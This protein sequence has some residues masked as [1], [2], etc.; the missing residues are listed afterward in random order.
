MSTGQHL[1]KNAINKK[2]K[3]TAFNASA[4]KYED[5]LPPEKQN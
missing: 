1:S 2:I 3:K 4:C 5:I